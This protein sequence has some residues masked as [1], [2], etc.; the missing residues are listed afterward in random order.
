L[1]ITPD[2][3]KDDFK[4]KKKLVVKDQ[5]FGEGGKL[6]LP[7][8]RSNRN[9]FT[10]CEHLIGM[11]LGGGR[12]SS[13]DTRPTACRI[14]EPGGHMCQTLRQAWLVHQDK[15]VWERL[16][17]PEYSHDE[18]VYAVV[19]NSNCLNVY[20][21]DHHILESLGTG[22]DYVHLRRVRDEEQRAKETK[23]EYAT[24]DLPKDTVSLVE[25]KR[26]YRPVGD[27]RKAHIAHE[28]KGIDPSTSFAAQAERNVLATRRRKVAAA[29]T[30]AAE[31][32]R[33]KRTKTKTR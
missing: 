31:S 13:Y 17:H 4:S 22:P 18:A 26:M 19:A 24:L 8:I 12:C 33:P 16:A 21:K 3:L 9:D 23:V 5:M 2:D 11:V 15:V 29:K 30:R 14:F 32:P 20:S 27:F 25:R 6:F 1:E 10:Q 7:V 28:G